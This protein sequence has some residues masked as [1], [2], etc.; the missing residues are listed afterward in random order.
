MSTIIDLY[1][2]LFGR[3]GIADGTVID[4]AEHGRQGGVST[5]QPYKFI[6]NV[7]YAIKLVESG[8][9]IYIAYANP[10]SLETSAVWKV[11]RLNTSGGIK[12][13][14]ADGNVNYD[15]RIDDITNLLYS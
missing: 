10:G 11:M 14:F 1:K 8:S 4:L 12:C 9:Y 2:T 6:D 5:G 3:K 15:N 7:N 13:E